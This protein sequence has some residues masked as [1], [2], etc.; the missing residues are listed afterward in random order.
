MEPFIRLGYPFIA[1]TGL[2]FGYNHTPK[3]P[4]PQ[5]ITN[6]TSAAITPSG[7]MRTLEESVSIEIVRLGIEDATLQQVEEGLNLSLEN[8]QFE[9]DSAVLL[10]SE[11]KKLDKIAEILQQYGSRNILVIGHTARAGTPA[12]DMAL[13]Q[14]RAKAVAGYLIQKGVRRAD[15]IETRGYGS[16]RPLADNTAE[17]GRRR[18]RRVEI[19]FRE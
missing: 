15:Q 17:E 11:I 6:E 5:N 12:T 7:I 16:D 10:P 19:I 8:M 2:I 1:G 4:Q 18:N 9:A 13:S 3:K 14:A